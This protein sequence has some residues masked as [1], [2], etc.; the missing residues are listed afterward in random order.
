MIITKTLTIKITKRNLQYYQYRGYICELKDIIEVNTEDVTKGSHKIIEVSCDRCESKNNIKLQDYWKC[1]DKHEY[2]I[3]TCFECRDVK[4]VL[5]CL[6]KYGTE[7]PLKNKKVKEDMN[8]TV[9]LKWG[10]INPSQSPIIKESKKQTCLM[11][12]GVEY[13]AQSDEI[14]TRTKD[15]CLKLY[16]VENPA[17]LEVVK[18]KIKETSL[19][20]YAVGNPAQSE[21]VK[22]KIRQSNINN[23]NWSPNITEY[24][25]YRNRIT[26]LTNKL[27]TELFDNWE[28]YD[29][30]DG[31]YIKNYLTE[32][33]SYINYPTID[34]KISVL[35]GFL[36]TIS[37]ED[38]A[39]IDNLCITKRYINSKKGSKT[40][41]DFLDSMNN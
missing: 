12:Y 10:V 34:H 14:K 7:H 24:T 8:N 3:Y 30:Y 28:G 41:K 32:S 27:K 5:T 33:S 1:Y 4:T 40:E 31:E 37:P 36:N 39:N 11:N 9:L 29:F 2:H 25:K 35:H 22:Y 21:E 19:K 38:I 20:K 17:Q 18:N 6:H 23:Y 26:Y 16:N 13:P 15:T